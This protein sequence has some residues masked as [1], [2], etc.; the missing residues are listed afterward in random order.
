MWTHCLRGFEVP[1]EEVP[2]NLLHLCK[3]SGEPGRKEEFIL[4]EEGL[5]CNS[6]VRIK[7]EE[8]QG[9][10]ATS[11]SCKAC[12]L[13]IHVKNLVFDGEKNWHQRC[14]ICRQCNSSLVNQKYYE[15]GS[16]GA[17][18]ENCFLARNLPTCFA[19][20][21]EISGAGDFNFHILLFRRSSDGHWQDFTLL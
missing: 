11:D 4:T 13:P 7:I 17:F 8:E 20:N 3:L 2:R 14:F 9:M 18:Y 6:C 21:G 16:E 15:K 12:K 10:E 19:C 1:G 5:Q